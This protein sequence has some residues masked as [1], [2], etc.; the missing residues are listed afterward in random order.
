MYLSANDLFLEQFCG[1]H[2]SLRGIS[3]ADCCLI[4]DVGII[5]AAFRC[6]HNLQVL[7]LSGLTRATDVSLIALALYCPNLFGLSLRS[8]NI[9]DFGVAALCRGCPLISTLDL[10]MTKITDNALLS[11]AGEQ[12]EPFLLTKTLGACVERFLLE[13]IKGIAHRA[14]IGLTAA[15]PAFSYLL[16]RTVYL[17]GPTGLN[18]QCWSSMGYVRCK[19]TNRLLWESLSIKHVGDG[20]YTLTSGRLEGNL[21]CQPNGEVLFAN[22]PNP[23]NKTPPLSELWG[24]ELKGE[25][26]RFVSQFTRGILQCAPDGHVPV[27]Y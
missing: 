12:P 21:Q 10:K 3:V 23:M 25:C 18:L 14:R 24:I 9:S 2:P 20:M 5:H 17:R 1:R 27:K 13:K 6:G 7:D 16:G 4:S 26:V 11:L 22:N 19:N 15:L 8:T